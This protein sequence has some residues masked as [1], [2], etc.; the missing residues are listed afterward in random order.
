MKDLKDQS[1]GMN[2][3]QKYKQKKQKPTI[4]KDFLLML[5]FKGLIDCLFLVLIILKM[6]I[7][8]LK[9]TVIENTFFQE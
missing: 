1:T 6:V 3:N 9:E 7:T 5:L 2:I 8:R 4:L